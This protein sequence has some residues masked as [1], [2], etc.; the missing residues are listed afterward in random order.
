MPTYEY[1]CEDCGRTFDVVQSFSDA[2]LTT[3]EVCGGMLRKVFAPV[4]IVFKG[5]GFYKTD[6]RTSSSKSAGT[7]TTDTK[8]TTESKDAAPS[9]GDKGSSDSATGTKAPASATTPASKAD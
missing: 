7:S 5:A 3:C 9:S 8:A 6:S 2:P 4:G 1:R